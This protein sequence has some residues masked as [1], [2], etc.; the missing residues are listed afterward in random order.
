MC[1]EQKNSKYFQLLNEGNRKETSND[2]SSFETSYL[3]NKYLNCFKPPKM[4]SKV[5]HKLFDTKTIFND[6]LLL[7]NIYLIFVL[8]F[9][10]Q[11]S[12]K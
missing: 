9:L 5:F 7:E 8:K 12:L 6:G 3:A 4:V 11:I 2:T 10:E 1:V